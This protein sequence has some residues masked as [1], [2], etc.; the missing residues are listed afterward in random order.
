MPSSQGRAEQRAFTAQPPSVV[1]TAKGVSPIDQVRSNG[2]PP[3][4]PTAPVCILRLGGA[5][6]GQT[7]SKASA[8]VS[9]R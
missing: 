4:E 7:R 1:G 3:T 9:Q 2:A 5:Q 8:G 6:E